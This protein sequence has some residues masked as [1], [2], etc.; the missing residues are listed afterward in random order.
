MKSTRESLWLHL[1]LPPIGQWSL[2]SCL[3][4]R[5]YR[6]PAPSDCL[7][8]L[9][10]YWWCTVQPFLFHLWLQILGHLLH[11]F[12]LISST[13]RWFAA[14]PLSLKPSYSHRV[15][16]SASMMPTQG[17]STARTP[18]LKLL[19]RSAPPLDF[20][21]SCVDAVILSAPQ[22]WSLTTIYES[23]PFL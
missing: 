11:L 16:A 18:S 8:S 19:S 13:Y 17:P 21:I 14:S 10:P 20:S 12:H 15:T 2:P 7:I 22:T 9:C 5:P 6:P 3:I 23:F 1:L 4:S